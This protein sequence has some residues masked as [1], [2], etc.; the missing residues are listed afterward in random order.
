MA[1]NRLMNVLPAFFR[2]QHSKRF[3]QSHDRL[4][5]VIAGRTGMNEAPFQKGIP[6]I[7]NGREA[8]TGKDKAVMADRI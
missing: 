2:K 8:R 3:G 6:G 4:D 7:G 1:R 5:P